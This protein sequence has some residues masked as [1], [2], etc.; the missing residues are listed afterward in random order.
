MSDTVV[1]QSHRNPLPHAWLEPCLQSVSHW[2]GQQGFDYRYIDDELFEALP[3]DLQHL[4][5]FNAVIASDLARLIKLREFLDQGHRMVIWCDA[6]FLIFNPQ[7]F[8]LI[9]DDYAL[10]REV[11]IQYDKQDRLRAYNKIHNAFLMFR[12][13]NCFLEFYIQTAHKLLRQSG[14]RIPAQFIGPKLLSA[15]H[16][17]ALCPVQE[18]AGML[19]PL[20]IRDLIKGGGDAL[21][22]FQK[23]SQHTIY[24]AN[25]CSSSIDNEQLSARQ[26]RMVIE[27]LL[28]G[29]TDLLEPA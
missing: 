25:L 19:S 13:G 29:G 3:A 24:A 27:T 20:V 21:D 16:N 15:L 26:M 1:L 17:I 14:E 11:W 28:E 4:T 9:D 7:E 22:L 10:G 2:A 5:E 6:D 12:S 23:E 18:S 8:N